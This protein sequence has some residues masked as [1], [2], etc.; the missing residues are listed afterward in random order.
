[1][2]Q[3]P[4]YIYVASSWKNYIQQSVITAIRAFNIDC[5]DFKYDEGANFHWSEVG[6]N[7]EIERVSDYRAAL[8]TDRACAGFASDKAALEK[9]DACIL[10]LPCGKSSHLELGYCIGQGKRTAIFTLDDEIQPELMYKMVD[11]ILTSIDDLF[12]WIGA[13]K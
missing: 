12:D 10:V 6:V 3:T 8:S 5:Y 2:S 13:P 11:N 4:S 9:A 1:M 7:S